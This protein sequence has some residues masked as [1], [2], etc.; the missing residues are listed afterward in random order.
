MQFMAEKPEPCYTVQVIVTEI[1]PAWSE[2]KKP[3]Y[4]Q[5]GMVYHD[6]TAREVLSLSVGADDKDE[7]ISKAIR[8][9]E[10]ERE[11]R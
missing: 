8:Q 4:P 7:A 2:P 11:D 9:L 1:T 10:V 5:D 3:S 6:E